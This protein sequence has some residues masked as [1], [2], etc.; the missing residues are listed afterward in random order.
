MNSRSRSMSTYVS[1]TQPVDIYSKARI[2]GTPAS[3][4]VAL[5]E[6]ACK[7]IEGEIGI[8]VEVTSSQ[9]LNCVTPIQNA[10]DSWLL[11]DTVTGATQ[12]CTLPHINTSIKT[13]A[14]AV[15]GAL[16]SGWVVRAYEETNKLS[17]T[18]PSTP[19]PVKFLFN[20]ISLQ[21]SANGLLGFSRTSVPTF[22]AGSTISSDVSCD[23]GGPATVL[24]VMDLPTPSQAIN[25][26]G[27]LIGASVVQKIPLCCPFMSLMTHRDSSGTWAVQLPPLNLNQLTVGLLT[28]DLLPLHMDLDWSM[29]MKVSYFAKAPLVD[30]VRLLESIENFSE[31]SFLKHKW[32][33][34]DMR[35]RKRIA[36]EAQRVLENL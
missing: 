33:E 17:F 24:V 13:L 30:A 29:T 3:F 25:I 11:I 14:G 35:Q 12:R 22:S 28:E 15:Q 32:T 6:D 7:A 2:S 36:A 19:N 10:N 4:T 5:P 27:Q 8:E 20:D 18:A 23:V 16:P 9:M 21:V 26:F 31:M 34:E 1:R